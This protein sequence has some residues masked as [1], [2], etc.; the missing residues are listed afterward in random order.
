MKR[1]KAHATGFSIRKG[2]DMNPIFRQ[3]L[4]ASAIGVI[5]VGVSA[6]SPSGSPPAAS[7]TAKMPMAESQYEADKAA[8]DTKARAAKTE[9]L[10]N[11]KEAYERAT[12]VGSGAAASGGTLGGGGGQGSAGAPKA[13]RS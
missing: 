1:T 6:Q 7:G 2:I 4:I 3:L 10:R 12:G 9:C 8:C 13:N 11:A 5:S